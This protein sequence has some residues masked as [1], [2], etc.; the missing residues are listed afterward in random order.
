MAGAA[1]LDPCAAL[2]RALAPDRFH[3]AL[4]APAERRAG[5]LALYA[6]DAEIARVPAVVSQP[7]AGEIRLQW[8]R[9]VVEDARGEEARGNPVAAAVVDTIT[10]AALPPAALAALIE[11][12]IFDLYDDPMPSLQDLEGYLGETRSAI[13]RLASLILAGG[14]DPGGAAAAGHA[15]VALGL[16]EVMERLGAPGGHGFLPVDLLARHSVDR[17]DLAAGRAGPGIRAVLDELRGIAARHGEAARALWPDISV[18]ARPAFLPL[19]TLEPRLRRLARSAEPLR[20]TP[21][22]G[23]RRQLAIWRAARRWG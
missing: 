19:A 20:P 5:L 21:L 14:R 15:G 8:W 4:F 1:E 10:T 11:A 7:I 12:R 2:V 3:A 17:A 22:P 23:W 16:V 6:F 9:E 18:E 13:I